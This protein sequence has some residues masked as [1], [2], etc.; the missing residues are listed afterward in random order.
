MEKLI[1]LLLSVDSIRLR[2]EGSYIVFGADV[3][4]QDSKKNETLVS[5]C[6]TYELSFRFD[7]IN[8]MKCYYKLDVH[9]KT[10]RNQA[11]S[12]EAVADETYNL[13]GSLD[14]DYSNLIGVQ[15]PIPDWSF[16]TDTIFAKW[17][18]DIYAK[19]EKSVSQFIQD[20]SADEKNVIVIDSFKKL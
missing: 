10:F 12:I 9:L 8:R 19:L 15:S 7:Y 18:N 5:S 6:E 3:C 2:K 4:E 13:R 14:V 17:K 1:L 11:F 16:F 20:Y